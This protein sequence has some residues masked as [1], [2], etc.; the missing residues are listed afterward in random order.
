MYSFFGPALDNLRRLVGQGP[1]QL[2]P[3]RR[4]T[5][6]LFIVCVGGDSAC[7]AS[8]S[9]PGALP[10]IRLQ[11]GM[12]LADAVPDADTVVVAIVDPASCLMCGSAIAGW[13]QWEQEGRS[14]RLVIVFAQ[15]PRARD[16]VE[17]ERA[18]L[19]TKTPVLRQPLYHTPRQYVVVQG[20]VTDS[21]IG[22]ERSFSFVNKYLQPSRRGPDTSTSTNTR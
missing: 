19:S 2:R 10:A 8:L 16:R 17:L 9:A 5:V 21:A 12:L 3:P 18:R 6:L 11:N 4:W 14:R 7:K 20:Q 22:P 13:Q 15:E 1:S